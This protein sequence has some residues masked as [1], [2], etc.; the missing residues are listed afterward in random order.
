M[1]SPPARIE[2][3]VAVTAAPGLGPDV[4]TNAKYAI[5]PRIHLADPGLS[6]EGSSSQALSAACA[7]A[8]GTF[9]PYSSQSSFLAPAR[10]NEKIVYH[11]ERTWEG[12]NFLT[13]VVRATQG[14]DIIYVAIVSFQGGASATDVNS[15]EYGTPKPELDQS[16][17]EINPNAMQALQSSLLDPSA[18]VMQQG[19]E[20]RPLDWRPHSL[21]TSDDPTEFRVR[22]YVRSP[23]PLSTRD[24]GVHL[25]AIAYASDEFFFGPAMAANPTAVGKGAKNVALGAT[26]THNVSFHDRNARMDE[27]IVLER[28]TTWGSEGRVMVRQMFWDMAGKMISSST[29][30]ALLRLKG[31]KI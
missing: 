19:A 14:V 18:S 20:D 22:G 17:E 6:L 28:E 21:E 2:P 27:W 1:T 30:E 24:C 3:H 10:R 11:V 7:T 15:L 16:A 13:R 31:A 4:Y 25:A 23:T 8:P 26:L 29:Q 5:L 12:R 9:Q